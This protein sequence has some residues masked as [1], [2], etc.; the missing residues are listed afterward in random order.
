MNATRSGLAGAIARNG[1]ASSG[2]PLPCTTSRA[3]RSSNVGAA[4]A[5]RSKPFCG[6]SRPI[7]PMTGAVVVRIEPD[8]RQQVGPAGRLAAPIRRASTARPGRRRSPDPRPSCRARSGS[9][10][11]GRPSRATRR[12]G[13]SRTR[14]SAPRPANPGET[15]LTSSARSMPLSSRSMPSASGGTTPSPS[16]RPSWPSASFGVQPWYARLWRV[17]RIA[18]PPMIGS[19]RVADVAVDRRRPR[20]A[21]RADGGRRP[22]AR[23]PGAPRA[24]R[25]RTARTATR[26]RGSR[27]R[28]RRRSHRDRRQPDGRPVAAGSHRRARR[29]R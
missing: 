8:P 9:R 29:G 27:R 17:I 13:P 16:A 5:S 4:S 1:S 3:P 11:S 6:S 12:R 10:R 18:A 24:P 7:I 2:W 28:R 21:N 22:A 20:C 14:A 15:V 25:G 19:V 23:R 26:C